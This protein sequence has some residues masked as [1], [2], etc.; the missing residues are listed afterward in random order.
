M[1]Y[2]RPHNPPGQRAKKVGA[3]LLIFVLAVGAIQWLVPWFFPSLFMTA[4]EPFWRAEFSLSSG[5][6]RSPAELLAE[7]EA[8]KRQLADMQAAVASSSVG[9]LMQENAELKAEFG[10][11]STTPRVLAAVLA[12]PPLA[13]YDELILDVGADKGVSTTTL[14]YAP[15]GALIGRVR[16]AFAHGAKA[17][18][19]TSPG[20][21]YPIMIGSAHIP[22]TAMGLGGG[23]YRADVPHGAAI[24]IGD[25]ASS[26]ALNDSLFGAVV[27][28]ATDPSDPFDTV[29]IAPPANPYQLRWVYLGLRP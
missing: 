4:A 19:L 9:F 10:R 29:F 8:L 25:A 21:T 5:A 6:V 22:A 12:R 23:Q 1:T 27:S 15:G 16:E 11:A 28:V 26:P 13:P 14:V 2:L 20:Q 17:I 24:Q 3:V 7:N 18:L